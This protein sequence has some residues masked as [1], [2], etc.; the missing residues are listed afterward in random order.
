MMDLLE[1]L[2]NDAVCEGVEALLEPRSL[3]LSPETE[4]LCEDEAEEERQH[5][6]PE[7]ETFYSSMF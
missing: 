2:C 6:H 7:A 3:A 5:L 1:G 4:V